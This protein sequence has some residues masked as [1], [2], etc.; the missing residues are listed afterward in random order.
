ML[1][2]TRFYIGVDVVRHLDL[3]A[4]HKLQSVRQQTVHAEDFALFYLYDPLE[5]LGI[6]FFDGAA[7]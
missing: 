1:E 5:K 3:V 2:N 7:Q 4:C 6:I